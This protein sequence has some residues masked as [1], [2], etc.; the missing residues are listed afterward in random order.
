MEGVYDYFCL[1]HEAGGMVG[2]LVVGRPAGPG[3]RA[4]D[5][6]AGQPGTHDWLPVPDTARRSFPAVEAIVQR[7]VVRHTASF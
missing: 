1:T 4:F 6:F 7:R 2:R 5:Y 3:T